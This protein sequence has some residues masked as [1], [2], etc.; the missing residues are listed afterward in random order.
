[1]ESIR[2][3]RVITMDETPVK[4]G[5]TDQ[6]ADEDGI[7]LALSMG[8]QDEICFLFYPDRQHKRV[9]QALQSEH[10]PSRCSPVDGW[11]WGL[12]QICNPVGID[13]CPM[14]GSQQTQVS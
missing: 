8:E 7:F 9:A 3:S 12:C 6:G 13:P 1:M 5:R 4:A 14:L 10:A 11:L 2:T